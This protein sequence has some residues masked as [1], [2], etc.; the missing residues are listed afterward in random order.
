M[1]LRLAIQTEVS[2]SLNQPEVSTHFENANSIR[3]LVKSIELGE[4]NHAHIAELT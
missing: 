2:G 4:V 3:A 1:K